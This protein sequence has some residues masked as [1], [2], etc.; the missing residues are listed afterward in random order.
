MH[1]QKQDVWSREPSRGRVF[2]TRGLPLLAVA[3]LVLNDHVLK[4]RFGAMPGL[5][6]LTGKLSDFAGLFFFPLFLVD[7]MRVVVR[8][9]VLAGACLATAIVFSLVKT[10]SLGHEIYSVGLG[11]LQWPFRAFVHRGSLPSVRPVRMTMD[12]TDLVAL[13][14]IVGAWLYASRCLGP[15]A[16][17]SRFDGAGRGPG[18]A[19]HER[20]AVVAPDALHEG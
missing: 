11:V 5:G 3:V 20:A 7:A 1:H 6:V 18:P 2:M 16:A 9:R 14:S 17:P 13:V 10:T 19:R 8:R 15:A 4:P 12:P